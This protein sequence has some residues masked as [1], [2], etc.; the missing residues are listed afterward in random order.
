V[1]ALWQWLKVALDAATSHPPEYY[2]FDVVCDLL[3]LFGEACGN[4]EV[5][6]LA[7]KVESWVAVFADEEQH[8]RFAAACSVSLA[9]CAFRKG[10]AS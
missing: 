6:L 10:S 1:N 8:R 2:M 9:G 5:Q 4:E 7:S 3:D